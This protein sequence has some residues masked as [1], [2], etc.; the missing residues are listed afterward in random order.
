MDSTA[1]SFHQLPSFVVFSGGISVTPAWRG[2]IRATVFFMGVDWSLWVISGI[3][4]TLNGGGF[5]CLV[6]VCQFLDRLFAGIFL[7]GKSLRTS[8]LT[9]ATITNL[10]GVRA[11]FV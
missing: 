3:F 8:T 5:Q 7:G 6:G 11:Q 2:L 1:S 4:Q 10:R 9:R